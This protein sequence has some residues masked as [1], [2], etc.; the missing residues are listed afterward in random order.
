[1]RYEI[2]LDASFFFRYNSIVNS[3]VSW[4]QSSLFLVSQLGLE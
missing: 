1:M 2:F 4:L 3:Y